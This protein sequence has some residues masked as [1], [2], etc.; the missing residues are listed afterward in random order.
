MRSILWAVL[1]CVSPTVFMAAQT[2]VD[3]TK[4]PQAPAT[5][6]STYVRPN[7]KVRFNKY[8]KDMF[9]PAAIIKAV[10]NA[11]IST[12]NSSPTEWGPH[13][14]GFGKRVA[15]NFGRDII[16]NTVKY[17]LDEAFTLDSRFYP[18]KKRDVRSRISNAVMSP[19]TTRNENG[20]RVLGFPHIIG[21]YTAGVVAAETWYPARYTYKDGLKMGSISLGMSAVYALVKEF[22]HKK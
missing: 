9:G 16:S 5:Q 19:V 10:G 13:W 11:G 2:P 12:A 8:V 14:D 17:G 18:S 4:T 6:T 20:K 7:G 21:V 15:S 22:I 3:D 1:L